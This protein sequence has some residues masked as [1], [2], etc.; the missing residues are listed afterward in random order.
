MKRFLAVFF[1]LASVSALVYVETEAQAQVSPLFRPFNG[2]VNKAVASSIAAKLGKLGLQP[3]DPLYAYTLAGSQAV[4]G[5]AIVAG[6]VASTVAA[7]GTAPVWLSVA[8]GLGAA[9]EIYD[10]T[11]GS[12]T[13]KAQPNSQI[14]LAPV[15]TY[16]TASPA[17]PTQPQTE[18]VALPQL[19]N[20][21]SNP[22]VGNAIMYPSDMP[23]CAS[24][25]MTFQYPAPMTTLDASL[26]SYKTATVCG[27]SQQA[28]RDMAYNQ[29]AYVVIRDYNGTDAYATYTLQ[30]IVNFGASGPTKISCSINPYTCPQGLQYSYA[31]QKTV[32]YKK[33]STASGGSIVYPS[34][35]VTFTY[36]IFNNPAFVDPAK[37][38]QVNDAAATL[39]NSDLSSRADPE[40][41]AAIAN[42][43][44]QQAAQQPGYQGAPY[45]VNNPVT[46]QDVMNDIAAGLYPWP[47]VADL[48]TLTIA[49]GQTVPQLDP[50][51]QP[52]EQPAGQPSTT[53]VDL[54]P[55]PATPAPDLEA[56]PTGSTIV[57]QVMGLLPNLSAFTM[58]AHTSEC[59]APTFDF[60]GH[61]Y[62]FQSM[63]DL[64]EEQRSLLSVIFSAVWGVSALTLVL[65]A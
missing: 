22:G 11:M 30:S 41:L 31:E 33:D 13:W 58:P 65:R 46:A 23:I 50:A 55:D 19:P 63:C 37:A 57:S 53:V 36:T 49:S 6:S 18:V 12:K 51:A 34:N 29:Y 28:V 32:N 38:Y 15:G 9:Y 42:K 16:V 26:A 27:A 40:L 4:V 24:V 10:F 48:L 56:A 14:T 64:L 62:S 8:L 25:S 45:D 21:Y 60:Y 47:T 20:D 59:S 3:S 2:Y 1:L 5:G 39:T 44:W 35:V 61:I 7:I 54:G 43:I 17:P 52:V